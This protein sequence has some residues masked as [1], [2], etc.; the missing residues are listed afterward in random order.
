[1]SH[2]TQII[3]SDDI[4]ARLLRE[5]KRTRLSLGE[6]VRRAVA[7][8]YGV[9]EDRDAEAALEDSLGAWPERDFDGEIYVERLRSG[10]ADRL[11]R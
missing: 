4:Y 11:G 1:M 3:L 5:S 9:G 10:M 6:L 7:G 8:T 2:R